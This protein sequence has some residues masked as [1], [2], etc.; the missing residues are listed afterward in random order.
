MNSLSTS[1]CCSIN[2][3]QPLLFL[4]IQET[5]WAI[6]STGCRS[7]FLYPSEVDTEVDFLA[8]FLTE[9]ALLCYEFMILQP[10]L[11]AASA[12]NLARIAMGEFQGMPKIVR[13]V[14]LRNRPLPCFF[15]EDV[16]KCSEMLLR[17]WKDYCKSYEQTRHLFHDPLSL[18]LFLSC[19]R[20]SNP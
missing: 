20:V 5:P 18:V 16:L 4:V 7:W 13:A 1:E 6:T 8:S 12:V 11:V 10:S 15:S 2:P 14:G 9:I 3:D 19:A 17:I